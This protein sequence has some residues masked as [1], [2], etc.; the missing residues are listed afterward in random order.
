MNVEIFF[1]I[2]HVV[3]IHLFVDVYGGKV[4]SRVLVAYVVYT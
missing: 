3:S 2:V 4:G 1:E